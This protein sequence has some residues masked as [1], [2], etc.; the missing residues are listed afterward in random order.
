MPSTK[1]KTTTERGLGWAHKQQRTRLLAR[2]HDGAPCPCLDDGT[3]GPA[4]LCRPHGEG[5]PMYRAAERN[6]DGLPLE[7][8]HSVARSQGGTRAD[9]LMLATCNRSRGAGTRTTEPTE[10]PKW[11]TREWFDWPTTT[12]T[13]R[14]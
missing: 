13:A 8:D 14:S 12:T 9:R 1:T 5:Q 7:A 2:H 4:C 3:C 11:W 6:P 10:R